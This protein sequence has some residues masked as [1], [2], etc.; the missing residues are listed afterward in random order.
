MRRFLSQHLPSPFG[1]G[2]NHGRKRT[3]PLTW[4]DGCCRLAV[5]ASG[6]APGITPE[7]RLER[8]LLRLPEDSAG[9]GGL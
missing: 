1:A 8:V 5:R 2:W 3:Q 4:F 6:E 7:A 9:H